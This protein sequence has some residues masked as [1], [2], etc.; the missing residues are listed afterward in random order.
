MTTC[1]FYMRDNKLTTVSGA[2]PG[3]YMV[4]D[5]YADIVIGGLTS[6]VSPFNLSISK[7]NNENYTIEVP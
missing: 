3:T 2:D 4:K 5:N 7:I 6:H 1:V